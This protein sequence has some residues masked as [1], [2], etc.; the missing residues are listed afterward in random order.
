MGKVHEAMMRSERANPQAGGSVFRPE[1]RQAVEPLARQSRDAAVDLKRIAP[2]LI[3]FYGAGRPESEQYRRLA[4]WLLSAAAGRALKRVLIASAEH[5]EGRTSVTINLACALAHIR[6]R[7]LVVDTDLRRPSI[8]K[9]LGAESGAGLVEAIS[10]ASPPG[11]AIVKV[12]PFGFDVLPARER[13]ENSAELLAS[14][15]FRETLDLLAVDYDFV[16]FDSPPLLAAGY[17]RL[18]ERVTDGMLLVIRAGETSSSEIS[19][20]VKYFTPESLLGVVLNR[21]R[22]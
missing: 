21:A 22:L 14:P 18:L 7:V 16:L 19:N 12:R 20:A 17:C 1:A 11:E 3:A 6:Q 4:I 9:L 13:L 8:M 10:G 15:A 5:G 2:H